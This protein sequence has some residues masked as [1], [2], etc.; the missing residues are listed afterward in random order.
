M[1]QMDDRKAPKEQ[2][3]IILWNCSSVAS[4]YEP[5]VL[6]RYRVNSSPHCRLAS[7]STYTGMTLVTS[8]RSLAISNERQLEASNVV[9]FVFAM[10]VILE[11]VIP[12]LCYLVISIVGISS[13]DF[14]KGGASPS[15]GPACLSN[16]AIGGN[17]CRG[18]RHRDLR[19]RQWPYRSDTRSPL[20]VTG[21]SHR[22]SC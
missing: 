17:L 20:D 1:R 6:L 3:V 21:M 22:G 18:S 11:V 15:G 8:G 19:L 14:H 2:I 10:S 9:G 13:R 16:T 12:H 5:A 7:T 4:L